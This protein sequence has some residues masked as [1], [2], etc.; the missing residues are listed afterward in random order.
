MK[1]NLE[2]CLAWR[3]IGGDHTSLEK[4]IGMLNMPKPIKTL[5]TVIFLR[6]AAKLVAEK[7]MNAADNDLKSSNDDDILDIW[8][9]S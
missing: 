7:S 8:C 3:T 4:K 9:F 6:D 5:I 1:L 2:Q